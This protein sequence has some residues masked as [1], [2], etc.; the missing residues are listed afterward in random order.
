MNRFGELFGLISLGLF[1]V[2]V[3]AEVS[4]SKEAIGGQV[5]LTLESEV[6]RI[7]VEPGVGGRIGSL[8]DKRS[9]FDGVL[10]NQ[11]YL[12]DLFL[13]QSYPGELQ[14]NPYAFEMLDERPDRVGVTLWRKAM[15]ERVRGIVVE[16]TVWLQPGEVIIPVDYRF[17]NESECYRS[18]SFWTQH[19]TIGGDAAT[20]DMYYRP[21]L[22]GMSAVPYPGGKQFLD[23]IEEPGAGWTAVYDSEARAG[24]VF[25]FDYHWL[26]WIYNS[27]SAA[28]VEWFMDTVLVAP[29]DVWKTWVMIAPVAGL[30]GITGESRSL[31]ADQSNL[32]YSDLGTY[33]DEGFLRR[34]PKIR[35][36]PDRPENFA[37]EEDDLLNLLVLA[38]PGFGRFRLDRME[39]ELHAKINWAYFTNRVIMNALSYGV[40]YFPANYDELS[41]YDGILFAGLGAYVLEDFQRRMVLDY[42]EVGGD[43]LVLGGNTAMNGWVGEGNILANIF[44]LK[45]PGPFYIRGFAVPERIQP[46]FEEYTD[47]FTNEL[48][49]TVE[50]VHQCEVNAASRTILI[51]GDGPLLVQRDVGMG[52]MLVFLGTAMGENCDNSFWN[53]QEW[54]AFLEQLFSR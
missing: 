32:R 29:G 16:K 24:T 27:F 15:G 53:W 31:L 19:F 41:L 50:F 36:F 45:N 21:G 2:P 17:R 12:L 47:I 44:P 1:A 9:G 20:D 54:P 18:F 6:F 46:V 14:K 38:G 37:L 49:P 33:P 51:A 43:V 34:P 10:P 23:V 26:R 25:L 8:I 4:V 22:A 35:S 28:T 13:H 11:G 40:D 30:D 48:S 39:K 3:C 5:L 7:V 42:L 52:R